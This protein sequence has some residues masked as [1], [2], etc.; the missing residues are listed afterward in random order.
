M[1]PTASQKKPQERRLLQSIY[2]RAGRICAVKGQA[3]LR[4]FAKGDNCRSNSEEET[5]RSD[6]QE[7][8]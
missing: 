5:V 4:D 1:S 7:V 2:D 8:A 3:H 6:V